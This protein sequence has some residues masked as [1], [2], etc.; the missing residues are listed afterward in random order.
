MIKKKYLISVLWI[1]FLLKSI[2]IAEDTFEIKVSINDKIITNHDIYKEAEYLK[3]LNTDLENLENEQIQNFAKNSLINEFIKLEEIKK[4][5]DLTQKSQMLEATF[6]NFLLNLNYN[7]EKEFENMLLS[8][9]N[10]SIKEVKQKLNIEL[11]WNES[12]FLRFRN[13]I[14]IDREKFLNK[15]KNRNNQ[16][17]NE[18]LLSEIIFTKNQGEDIQNKIK[19]IRSS[20]KEI[21]FNNTA[22]IYSESES[23]KIGGKIG[24]VNENSL[25]EIISQKIKDLK[26]GEHSEV[27]KI[28][29]NFLILNIDNIKSYKV[30]IDEEEELNKLINYETN[31]QL[32]QFSNILFNRIKLNYYIDEK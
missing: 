1:F 3:I 15:I 12:I 14:K 19:K 4:L 11:L 25:S 23:A 17:V 2:G 13:Q 21:G 18:Y 22:N 31:L 30:K 10:Y 5:F 16:V 7:N 27:M 8:K 32:K 24:W 29:N 20:I 26:I 9:K 6:K 28:G